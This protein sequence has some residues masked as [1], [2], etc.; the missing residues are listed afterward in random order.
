[1]WKTPNAQID[2]LL[3]TEV[4]R[5][6]LV[7]PELLFSNSM[8]EAWWRSLKHHRL[9]LHAWTASQRRAGWWRSTSDHRALMKYT[10]PILLSLSISVV[11]VTRGFMNSRIRIGATLGALVI[12]IAVWGSVHAMTSATQAD[13]EGHPAVVA[14]LMVDKDGYWARP[15]CSGM[16][17]SDKVVLT[18][19]HCL[20]PALSWQQEGHTIA[21]SNEATL[22]LS[23]DGTGWF[24]IEKLLTKVEV[25]E[26][27]LNPA[28]NRNVIN[29]YAHDV[30]AAV[31]ATPII[32]APSA[33]PTLPPVGMLDDLKAS[34]LLRSATFTVLGYGREEK[35]L[36]SNTT[37]QTYPVT[38]ERRFGLL[39]YD[40]LE[41]RLL[42][43]SQRIS[44]NEGGACFGDSGGPSLLLVG[45]TTYVVGVTSSG[46]MV[47]FATNTATRT[48]SQEAIDLLTKVLA[49]NP[50]D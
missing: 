37:G 18:A 15:F 7:M 14:M 32:I 39:G 29:N 9:F 46:D 31:L 41:P 10:G 48:D 30:S 20:S 28:Y 2:A 47:C 11:R 24:P 26:I 22:P 19:S 3:A 42:H 1:M 25:T 27:V 35:V 16:L 40:A 50:N 44:K 13:G 33:L 23:A 21:V 43:E 36:P 17:L 12:G 6:L 45:E 38:G 4:L 8:I 5:R 49:D 34:K